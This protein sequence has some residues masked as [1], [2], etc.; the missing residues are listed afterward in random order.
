MNLIVCVQNFNGL[1]VLTDLVKTIFSPTQIY[2]Y[3]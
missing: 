2:I 3:A 1:S